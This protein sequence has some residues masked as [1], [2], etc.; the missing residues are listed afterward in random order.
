MSLP[1]TNV[2]GDQPRR[3]G[4]GRRRRNRSIRSGSD[5]LGLLGYSDGAPQRAFL[6][7]RFGAMWASDRLAGSASDGVAVTVAFTNAR[8]C[9]LHLPRRLMAQLHL[10]QVTLR[11]RATDGSLGGTGPRRRGRAPP[12]QP[13]DLVQV[14]SLGHTRL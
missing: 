11:Q 4:R 1:L 10:L 8:D 2:R 6:E 12:V 14:V 9:F 7:R 3:R 5:A 13:S